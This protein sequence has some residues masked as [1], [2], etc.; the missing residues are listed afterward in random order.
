[1][2]YKKTGLP[3]DSD[4]VLC[5][6][7]NIQYSSVFVNIDDYNVSG[8]IHISEIAAGRIRNIRDYVKEGK[9]VVCK[10]LKV[11]PEKGHVDLSLRRVN[12]NQRRNKVNEVKFE[13]KAESIIEQVAKAN[14]MPVEKLYAEVTKPI[15]KDYQYLHHAFEDVVAEHLNLSNVLDKKIAE[16]ITELVMQRFKPQIIEISGVLILSSYEGNGIETIREAL[17]KGAAVDSV[18]IT[19]LGGGK[20]KLVVKGS[21]Y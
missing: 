9:K 5:T 16:Q 6:V 2:L 20:Y 15:L 14:N 7:T 3:E 21:D 17:L 13:Q 10:V 8:M 4:L 12:E 1:M 18:T 19:Y 11:Y